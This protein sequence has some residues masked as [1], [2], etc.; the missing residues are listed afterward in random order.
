MNGSLRAPG[1]PRADSPKI[2]GFGVCSHPGHWT[3]AYLVE[4]EVIDGQAIGKCARHAGFDDAGVYVVDGC[5][6]EERTADGLCAHCSRT[7][8]GEDDHVSL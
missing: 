1:A 2:P 4:G 3:A 7:D 8:D 6:H 5:R